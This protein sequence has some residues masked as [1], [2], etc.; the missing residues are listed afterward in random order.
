MI[1]TACC[2]HQIPTNSFCSWSGPHTFSAAA[3]AAMSREEKEREAVHSC[4][5]AEICAPDDKAWREVCRAS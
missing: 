2:G 1:S 5:W 4:A 3:L